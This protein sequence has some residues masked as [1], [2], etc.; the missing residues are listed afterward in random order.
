MVRVAQY[1]R[2]LWYGVLVI[3]IAELILMCHRG[4]H[5]RILLS[6]VHDFRDNISVHFQEALPELPSNGD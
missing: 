6:G 2:S 1:G 4:Y 3:N 5:D